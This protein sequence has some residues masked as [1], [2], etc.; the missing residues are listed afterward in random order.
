MINPFLIGQQIYLSP[1]SVTD[2][3]EKYIAWLNDREVCKDNA[4]A[5][6]PNNETKAK[7][8]VE[9]IQKSQTDLVFAIRDKTTDEHVG[10][11]SL[12]GINWVNKSAELAILI[13][14]KSA[15]GKGLGSECYLLL[16]DYAFNT[17]NLNRVSSGQTSRNIGMIKICTKAGMKKEG[18]LRAVLFKDDEY[19]DVEVYAILKSEH[20]G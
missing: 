11:V 2:I 17:L 15:W 12:Q 16:L 5:T 8:Y 10:N 1:I 18:V 13:G 14:E 6:F 3:G 4:H 9:S 19:L 7:A 20:N